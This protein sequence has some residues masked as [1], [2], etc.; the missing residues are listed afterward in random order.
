M[1]RMQACDRE[2]CECLLSKK[3]KRMLRMRLLGSIAFANKGAAP[4]TGGQG[5]RRRLLQPAPSTADLTFSI[6]VEQLSSGSTVTPWLIVNGSQVRPIAVRWY[7][8]TE[9]MIAASAMYNLPWN[10]VHTLFQCSYD[11][12]CR[13]AYHN[14]C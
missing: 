14:M 3:K 4:G 2:C 7:M 13:G 1:R 6:D 11:L 8:I 12:A 5:G 9:F 10:L